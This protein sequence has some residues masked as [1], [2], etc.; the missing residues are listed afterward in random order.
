[1]SVSIPLTPAWTISGAYMRQ[2]VGGENANPSA[3]LN[4][5]NF[6]Q[7]MGKVAIAFVF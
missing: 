1:M 3:R 6:S 5:Q 2:V 7:N 4:T